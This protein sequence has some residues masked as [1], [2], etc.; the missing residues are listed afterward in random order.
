VCMC[1]CICGVEANELR[2]Q[3]QVRK[4]RL[5]GRVEVRTS[6]TYRKCV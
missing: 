4:K 3:G 2:F 6:V 1:M 5:K